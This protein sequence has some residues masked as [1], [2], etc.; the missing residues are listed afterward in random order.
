[1]KKHTPSHLP[2][3]ALDWNEA[4]SLIDRLGKDGRYRD[5]MLIACGCYLGLRIS[6]ILTLKWDDLDLSENKLRKVEKKTG[7]T[8]VLGINRKL[9]EHAAI[10]KEYC[11]APGE[12]NGYIFPSWRND[13]VMP[14]SRFWAWRVLKEM[15]QT[16]RIKSAKQ[17][18]TH[19]LRKTFGRRI[20]LQECRRGRGDQALVLLQ[21]IFGHTSVAITKRYLGIREE[22]ILSI[23]NSLDD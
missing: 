18:S 15:Q 16:Y 1:M 2:A 8:R 14:L 5:S 7:K 12:D 6:D 11:H 9:A 13:S 3:D 10:C 17:F 19:T 21:E 4:M 23:Y 22:E 20:W